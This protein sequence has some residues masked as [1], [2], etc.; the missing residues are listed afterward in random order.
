[1]CN[2]CGC[3][4]FE[5]I[6]PLI[7]LS[8]DYCIEINFKHGKKVANGDNVI[9]K[10]L[11]TVLKFDNINMTKLSGFMFISTNFR[12]FSETLDFVEILQ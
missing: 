1:M 12:T 3:F 10:I 6:P 5:Q 7:T 11:W 9:C 8:M 4:K 2:L